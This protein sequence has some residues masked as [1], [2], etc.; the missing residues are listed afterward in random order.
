MLTLLVLV[1]LSLS[2]SAY[3]PVLAASTSTTSTT[4]TTQPPAATPSA[5]VLTTIPPRLPAD[6]GIYPAVVVSLSS[7]TGQP[8]LALNGTVVFLTSSQEGV[9]LV[10]SQVIIPRG[11]SFA[12]ANF[13]TTTTPGNSTISAS[14]VG[15]AAV[16]AQVETVTPSGFATRLSVIP[17]PASQLV[18]PNGQGTILVETLDSAGFP[19]K[20]S[21]TVAVSLSSSNNG[22]VS[23]P[24]ASLTV[25]S[26]SVLSSVTYR[27]GVTPGVATITGSASG[28]NSG[29]GTVT[30]QG[31]SPYALKVFAQPDPIATSAGGRL[32]VTL[33]DTQGNPTPAPVAVAVAISSS[34]TSLVSPVQSSTIPAGQVYAVAS[35]SSGSIAGTANLTVSSPGLVSSFALVT[36][37]APSTPV[38]LAI[39]A[40]PDPVLANNG[41]Y[42]SIVVA[43][44]DAAGNPAVASSSVSV[45]LTSSD[46]SVGSV[47][48]S[49]VIQPGSSYAVAT[50]S[51]TFFV[52]STFITALAQNLQ[53]AST[54]VTSYGP[55]PTQVV[56]KVL[57]SRLP[58]DGGQYSAVE[59][60]LEDATGSPAVAP[61][62]VAV[63]LTSS[64]PDIATVSPTAVISAGQ[65]YILTQVSTTISPGTANIT[66]SSSGFASSSTGLTTTSPAPSKLGFYVAPARG[67]QSFGQKGDALVAV[68]LQDSSSNPARAREAAAVVVTSSNSSV[69][70]KPLQVTIPVGA[71][72]AW[73]LVNTTGPG[74]TTLTASTSGLTSANG[75]LSELAIPV[76]VTLTSS[77]PTAVLGTT[78]TIQLQAEVLGS[79]LQGASVSLTASSGSMSAPSGTTDSSG[80][81]TDTFV[82]QQNG[83][84]TITAVVQDPLVGNVTASTNV[85]VIPPSPA[86]TGASTSHWLGILLVVLPVVIVVVIVVVIG[87][88]VRR[89]LKRRSGEPEEYTEK[90]AD[91]T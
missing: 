26:G 86:A 90:D 34:N 85:L 4:T 14:S 47:S 5:L 71:D 19:A 17:V 66:A 11:A 8:S 25:S 76:S 22:V 70:A 69:M 83:I 45:T 9:G 1:A 60:M 35:F 16:S 84:A 81:L 36:V 54:S 3:L 13:T 20:A 10:S 49:V 53:S 39:L 59:V 61:V 63:Q 80:E 51:S 27:V 79:P 15:L 43:L 30:V 7:S 28:F 6:G 89:M 48:G 23:L 56:V 75:T 58:A 12:V 44:T 40:T 33:T 78:T 82:A 52:G 64:S 46:S 18:N 88:A 77:A 74:S 32:V 68:Q 41:S 57:P 50:F 62:A 2:L 37:A 55:I 24:S 65:S 72:Y 21:S 91:A 87:L 31:A 67:I 38:K 73:A 42:S 29:S